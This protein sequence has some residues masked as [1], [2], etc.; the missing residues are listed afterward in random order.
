MNLS[1][2]LGVPYRGGMG[3]GGGVYHFFLIEHDLLISVTYVPHWSCICKYTCKSKELYTVQ[4]CI[5]SC[6][7]HELHIQAALSQMYVPVINVTYISLRSHNICYGKWM[8]FMLYMQLTGVVGPHKL[9]IPH[10]SVTLW[11]C[12]TVNYLIVQIGE[13]ITWHGFTGAHTTR[14]VGVCC[15]N[16]HRV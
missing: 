15:N 1:G 16:T 7:P 9:Y 12:C 2:F 11:H 5:H 14:L 10:E 4:L 8:L 13:Y 3:G 6:R